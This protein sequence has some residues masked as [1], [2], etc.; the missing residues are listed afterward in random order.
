MCQRHLWHCDLTGAHRPA[1]ETREIGGYAKLTPKGHHHDRSPDGNGR[2]QYRG[3]WRGMRAYIFFHF[4]FFF[5]P[6]DIF[7]FHFH[8]F[9]IFFSFFFNFFFNFFF[10]F[11]HLAHYRP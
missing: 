9:F 6:I 4:H 8:F 7:F 3:N 11:F 10:I 1:E 2:P 5:P